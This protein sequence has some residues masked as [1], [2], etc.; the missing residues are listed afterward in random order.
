MLEQFSVQLFKGY[1]LMYQ[2]QQ[3]STENLK[4]YIV[5][6]FGNEQIRHLNFAL[7]IKLLNIFWMKLSISIHVRAV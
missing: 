3:L 1:P 4:L 5:K 2:P 6:V 7:E